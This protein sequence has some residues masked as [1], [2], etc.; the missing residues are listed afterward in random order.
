MDSRLQT[1]T[2]IDCRRSAHS[3]PMPPRLPGALVHQLSLAVIAG[4]R[5]F[6]PPS[7]LPS[8]SSSSSFPFPLL[9]PPPP[10]LP[11]LAVASEGPDAGGSA[12]EGRERPEKQEAP[13]E[14]GAG[15]G[16][17]RGKDLEG[18]DDLFDP[19]PHFGLV[20]LGPSN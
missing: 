11:F 2:V 17:R 5:G 4:G 7:P 8:S 15:A 3:L 20:G 16:E 1:L 6:S 14:E 18:G 19:V 10:R 12:G 13:A 9:P